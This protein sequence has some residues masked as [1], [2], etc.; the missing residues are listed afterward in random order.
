MKGYTAVPP[1]V[2]R[3]DEKHLPEHAIL[4][5][6]G[7]IITMSRKADRCAAQGM[8]KSTFFG[9]YHLPVRQ[10]LRGIPKQAET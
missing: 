9:L 1:D 7:V 6:T 5:C 2:V 4:N 8:M 3:V 10:T